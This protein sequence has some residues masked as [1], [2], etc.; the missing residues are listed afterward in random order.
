MKRLA[1][2]LLLTIFCGGCATA[3]SDSGRLCPP[4]PSAGAGV[5]RELESLC[6]PEE[7]CPALWDWLQRL[8]RLKRQLDAC[9]A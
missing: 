8:D 6:L 1:L 3:G 9:R 4:W 2:L 5:A 7:R